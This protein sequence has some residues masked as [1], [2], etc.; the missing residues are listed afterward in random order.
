VRL[1]LALLGGALAAAVGVVSGT[2]GTVLHL[3]W[4][5]LVLALGTAVV[6][7]G[8]LPAGGV[9]VAFALGWCV[10]VLRGALEGPGGGFLVG[11]DAAGWSLL[12]ASAVLLVVAVATVRGPRRASA[13]RADDPGLRGSGT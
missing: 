7:L 4:W 9:R 1:L 3:R 6:V 5:G 10:P 11:A 2:A 12:A 13:G 8:W